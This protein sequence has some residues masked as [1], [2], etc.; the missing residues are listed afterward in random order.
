MGKIGGI[1]RAMG[2]AKWSAWLKKVKLAKT[3]KK[4]FS[5]DTLDLFS[6]KN[7]SKKTPNIREMTSFQK[8]AKQAAMQRLQALQNGQF[9]SKITYAKN[10]PKTCQ[11]RFQKNVT[12]VL[13]EKG[14]PKTP[15]I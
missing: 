8:S 15:N 7:G 13:C 3:Y 6:S 2:F 1:A 5:T 9:G 4:T 11:K 12:V 14:L 10:M